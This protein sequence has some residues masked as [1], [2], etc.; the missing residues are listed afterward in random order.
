MFHSL[1]LLK[2]ERQNIFVVNVLSLPNDKYENQK[3]SLHS[4]V[5]RTFCRDNSV[6]DY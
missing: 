6:A 4:K 3:Q 2:T 5:M 1:V